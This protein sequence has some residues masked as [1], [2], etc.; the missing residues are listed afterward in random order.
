MSMLSDKKYIDI[1][2]IPFIQYLVMYQ[3]QNTRSSIEWKLLYPFVALLGLFTV[4]SFQINFKPEDGAGSLM[5]AA[6]GTQISANATF[7]QIVS[8]SSEKAVEVANANVHENYH[9]YILST[10]LLLVSI[11][12][13]FYI[14]VR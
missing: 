11:F 9:F 8:G 12:Y 6:V 10:I 14:E 3:W 2:S 1:M 13:F 4:W 7:A 5:F